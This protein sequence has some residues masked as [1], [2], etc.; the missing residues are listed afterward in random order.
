MSIDDRQSL[1]L[2][3]MS[4]AECLN[5]LKGG[6]FGR[7]SFNLDDGPTILP[8][9]YAFVDGCIVMRTAR[10]S[11]L[12]MTPMTQVAFEIDDVDTYRTW[13]WSVVAR[14]RAFDITNAVDEQSENLRLLPFVPWLRGDRHHVIKIN[15]HEVSGRRFGIPLPK[16]ADGLF[17]N[18]IDL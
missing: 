12:A 9:N 2:E 14:G 5:A 6:V 16:N 1:E 8:V 4:E 13:G 15:V 7:L 3:R 17:G 11:K 18:H 10:G